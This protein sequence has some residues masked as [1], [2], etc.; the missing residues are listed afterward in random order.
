MN[1]IKPGTEIYFS[2]ENDLGV[3]NATVYAVESRL[4]VRTLSLFARARYPNSDGK[5]KP[6]Q[7][8]SVRINL[9]QINNAIVIPS[10]SSIKEMG[11]DIAY[12]YDNGNAREVEI[13]TGMR[14]S[15]SVEVISGLNIGD[16]LLTTG[17]MQLRNGM[18]VQIGQMVE[19]RAD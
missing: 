5:M 18:P 11:R 1:T 12:V 16:T 3:Y 9:D 2:V 4:D 7:S 14:T 6:G 13:V 17:V 10:I 15:A 8:A 19:N